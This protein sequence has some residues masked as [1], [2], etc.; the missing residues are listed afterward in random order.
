MA[1]QLAKLSGF[2]Q[3]VTTASLHDAPF[4]ES[5]GATAVVDRK[6]S[7]LRIE[8]IKAAKG[9][10][11]D[12]VFDAISLEETYNV[13]WDVLGPGGTLVLVL[14]AT[15]DRAKYPDKKIVDDIAGNVYWPQRR[16]LGVSLYAAL[17]KLIE[18]GAIKVHN[19]VF[20][21]KILLI[22]AIE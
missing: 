11:I 20:L 18:A 1:I 19:L 9:G 17:P 3:I 5:I 2:S 22:M 7:D 21:S 14:E 6:A 16:T 12:F 13:A 10:P 8:L 4:L 15:I